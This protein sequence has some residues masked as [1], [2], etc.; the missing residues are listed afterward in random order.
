MKMYKCVHEFIYLTTKTVFH[1][2]GAWEF[3][4]CQ[5]RTVSNYPTQF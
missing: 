1:T 2:K 4:L 3:N 5:G